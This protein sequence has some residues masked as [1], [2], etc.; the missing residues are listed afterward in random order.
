MYVIS[1]EAHQ[2]HYH[3]TILGQSMLSE[4][5]NNELSS[6]SKL[7]LSQNSAMAMALMGFS[8]IQMQSQIP[9]LDIYRV[10]YLTL[11]KI[12]KIHRDVNKEIESTVL[13]LKILTFYKT[14]LLKTT[15]SKFFSLQ[16][17]LENSSLSFVDFLRKIKKHNY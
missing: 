17:L 4:D 7:V 3:C 9:Y 11:Q 15:L 5:K 2:G 10:R 14:T 12:N 8:N 1:T 6:D 16:I 13:S